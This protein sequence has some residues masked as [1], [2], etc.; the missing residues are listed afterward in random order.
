VTKLNLQHAIKIEGWSNIDKLKVIAT[1]ARDAKTIIEVGSYCGRSARAMLDN[2]PK[3]CRLIAVDTWEYVY[4]GGKVSDE[5]YRAFMA[6]M[7]VYQDRVEVYKMPSKL[8]APLIKAEYR[9]GFAD[10]IFI[11]GAHTYEAV[12]ADIA[13]Y[14]YLVKPGGV[15]CG[16][17]Y[18]PRWPGVTRAVDEA[19]PL[20]RKKHTIWQVY[21]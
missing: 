21:L 8:A 18:H 2:A 1:L 10:L 20:A 6:N 11:D 15:L 12:K 5:H 9:L 7:K 16:D 17:D 4:R 19:F 3:D 13:N 14:R